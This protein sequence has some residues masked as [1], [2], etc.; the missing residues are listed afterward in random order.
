MSELVQRTNLKRTDLET[1]PVRLQQVA[2]T[3]IKADTYDDDTVAPKS[4]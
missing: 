4:V 1:S 3:H 2:G